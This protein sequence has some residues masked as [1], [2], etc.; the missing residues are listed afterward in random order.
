ML[1]TSGETKRE[2]IVAVVEFV[3]YCLYIIRSNHTTTNDHRHRV[4]IPSFVNG[5]CKYMES[6]A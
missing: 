1:G 6:R 4:D 3:S 2:K 5:K